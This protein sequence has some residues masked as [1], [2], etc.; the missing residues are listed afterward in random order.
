[1]GMGE[2]FP[3]AVKKYIPR[4]RFILAILRGAV[5]EDN[6]GPS[7]RRADSNRRPPRRPL[8]AGIEAPSSRRESFAPNGPNSAAAIVTVGP[9]RH[10]PSGAEYAE[11]ISA[12]VICGGVASK[13]TG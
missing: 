2:L 5:I 6:I 3:T 13:P 4:V 1:M 7:T 8:R 12:D 11:N 9:L 10:V